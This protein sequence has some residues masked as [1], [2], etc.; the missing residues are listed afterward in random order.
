[1]DFKVFESARAVKLYTKTKRLPVSKPRPDGCQTL[2]E[3]EKAA[4]DQNTKADNIYTKTKR[5]PVSKQK[6]EGCQTI[7]EHGKAASV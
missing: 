2:N 7:S 5:L 1:M 4:S 3:N 6:C